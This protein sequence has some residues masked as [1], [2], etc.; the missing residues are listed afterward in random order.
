MKLLQLVVEWKLWSMQVSKEVIQQTEIYSSKSLSDYPKCQNHILFLH[1]ITSCDTTSAMFRRSKTS[2]LKLFKKKDLIDCAKVFNEIDPSAQTI[3]RKGIRFLLAVYGV[4]KKIDYIDMY[5]YLTFVKNT[6]N[7]KQ[8]QLSCLPPTSASAHQHL[9]WAFYQVQA[10]LGNQLNPEDWDWKLTDNILELIQAILP[11]TPQKLL[12]T[13]FC[14]CKK[15]CSAKCGCRR[16]GLSCSLACTNCQSQS[17][18][19]V[20]SNP[21]DEDSCDIDEGTADSSSVEQFMDI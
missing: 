9:Y 15:D 1:A 2:V 10:W 13:I 14:N 6:R 12:N 18:L 21:I 7:K 5:R 16:V 17:C 3:I 11:P 19:N 20:Q 4:P 8:V